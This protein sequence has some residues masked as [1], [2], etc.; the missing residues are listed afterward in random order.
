MKKLHFRLKGIVPMLMHNAQT[1]DP[2]NRFTK[3]IKKI[4]SKRKKTDADY[5]AIAKLEYEAG[6]YLNN[7]R[8]CVPGYIIEGVIY[9]RGGAAR[10]ERMGK[11]AQAAIFCDEDLILEYDGPKAF[12]E[13]W[14]DENM[15]DISM[16]RIQSS[17]IIRTRPKIPTGWIVEGELIYNEKLVNEE[18]VIHWLRMAGEECG[19]MDW[20]PKYGRF[21]AEILNGKPK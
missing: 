20:R 15:R 7:G 6:L 12:K 1:A 10:K 9:G 4:S 17:K 2:L 11:Q 14:A 18:E 3:A 5:E 13:M 16:V 21:K 19:L 8:P